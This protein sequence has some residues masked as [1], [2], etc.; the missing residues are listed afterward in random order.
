MPRSG[1]YTL[2][3]EAAPT[4]TIICAKCRRRGVYSTAR[5]RERWGD[6]PMPRLLT[7]LSAD[8]PERQAITPRCSA[9]FDDPIGA[10]SGLRQA[11]LD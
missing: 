6:I 9:V 4:V 3:D 11:S 1:A 7:E 10:R 2:S 8:C 5:L